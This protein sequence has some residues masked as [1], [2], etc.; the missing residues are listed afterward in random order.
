MKK[1]YLFCLLII[2]SCAAKKNTIA[3]AK[4]NQEY[5]I[6]TPKIVK[7]S[8][9]TLKYPY[10]HINGFKDFEINTSN[11]IKDHNSLYAK[12]LRFNATYSSFYTKKVMYE[13]FGLWNETYRVH[14]EKHP[15]LIWKN[16]NLLNNKE[17]Y[18]VYATGFENSKGDG[19][20]VKNNRYHQQVKGGNYSIYASI[21]V[22]DANG[23]DCLSDDDLSLKNSMIAYFSDGIKNLTTNNEFYDLYW[24]T[25]RN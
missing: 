4:T 11:L 8:D 5:Q 25:V 12:E 18:T 2:L 14:K 22:L 1:E 3:V 13:K 23:K 10:L 24:K 20:Q 21:M 15:V 16:V 6:D 7:T 9:Q 19:N 17:L